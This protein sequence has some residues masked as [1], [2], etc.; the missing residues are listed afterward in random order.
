MIVL[1]FVIVRICSM[2]NYRTPCFYPL[3]LSILF[4][5]Y[6][7]R[8]IILTRK[9]LLLLPLL[10]LVKIM[11]LHQYLLQLHPQLVSHIFKSRIRRACPNL[12]VYILYI[13]CKRP[14]FF[15]FTSLGTNITKRLVKRLISSL[16]TG[17]ANYVGESK[18]ASG[19]TMLSWLSCSLRLIIHT[20]SFSYSLKSLSEKIYAIKR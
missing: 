1:F 15:L 4:F 12:P 17:V 16:N 9:W 10:L 20:Y 7:L 11:D 13:N 5:T 6:C 8:H 3:I 18:L 2:Y 14:L 19:S